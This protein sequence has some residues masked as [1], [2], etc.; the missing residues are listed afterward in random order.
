M[1]EILD[2]KYKFIF[3]DLAL[4]HYLE[5]FMECEALHHVI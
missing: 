4:V 3:H 1:G 5:I 2:E